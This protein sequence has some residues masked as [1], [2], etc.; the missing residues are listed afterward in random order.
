MTSERTDERSAQERRRP[1]L[2]V[3]SVAAAVLL[4]GGGGAYWAASASGGGESKAALGDTAAS[5]E[6]KA[7]GDTPLPGIAPGEHDPSGGGVVY[8]AEGTLPKGPGSAPSY[9]VKGEVGKDE[10][11]RLA[12]SLGIAGE[13]RLVGEQWQ[14]GLVKD[15]GGMRLT[16]GRQ[17]PGAWTFSAYHPTGGD[18]CKKGSD[19]CG[20]AV[21][22][23]GGGTGTPVS[24]AAAKAAAAPVLK[25]A[26]QDGAKL[27]AE[28][29]H[30]AT[31]Y[32][33]AD[34]VIG[35]LPTEGWRTALIIGPDG[36]VTGG[37]GNLK[38]PV[39][40][41]QQS[42]ITADQALKRLNAVSRSPEIDSCAT[43]VPNVD[44]P[45][46]PGGGAG[47]PEVGA[48]GPDTPVSD[49]GSVT[50][51]GPTS[52]DDTTTADHGA[53]T[54]IGGGQDTDPAAPDSVAPCTQSPAPPK[55]PRTE[56]VEGAVLGLTPRA[57][58]QGA[59]LVPAWLFTVAGRD[60]R[61]DHTVSQS[62]LAADAP[63][64]PPASAPG[65]SYQEDGRRLTVHFW[66]GVCSTY[67]ASVRESAT[68]VTVKITDTP[69]DPHKACIMIAKEMSLT[70]TLE[71][72]LGDR[73]VI[74]ATTGKTL[75]R[76]S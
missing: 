16:V 40:D 5:R 73:K 68:A 36:Q 38:A 33:N 19:S 25:A 12:A 13:P 28:V 75:P 57:D 7:D 60:G 8:V 11:A 18:N 48:A 20:P 22:P 72:P 32:V 56:K 53:A 58:D 67:S 42:V 47:A 69:T 31:R 50:D 61:P 49:D 26:G 65:F 10:V 52:D 64:V 76:T 55:Q 66:G 46:M 70:V 30:G 45:K 43:P 1:R 24:E 34:P 51:S 27:E 39:R 54:G 37:S 4:A 35:G 6:Q 62:A 21:L 14:A 9:D 44:V 63:T 74:D 2:A 59:Q 29:V 23:E 71:Q 15:P 3:V 41:G 17:A